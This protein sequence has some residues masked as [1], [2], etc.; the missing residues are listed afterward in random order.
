MQRGQTAAALRGGLAAND[1]GA[2]AEGQRPVPSGGAVGDRGLRAAALERRGGVELDV[3]IAAATS[4]RGLRDETQA[5]RYKGIS[6]LYQ[7]VVCIHQHQSDGVFSTIITN[8]AFDLV[9]RYLL[10]QS[11]QWHTIHSK[12]FSLYESMEAGRQEDEDG[13]ETIVYLLDYLFS[14]LPGLR[15]VLTGNSVEECTL[16]YFCTMLSDRLRAEPYLLNSYLRL[17]ASIESTS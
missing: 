7:D 8:V 5:F 10:V 11:S 16:P 17:R 15:I 1:A 3:S 6:T 13:L 4:R 9:S 12:Q 2:A 14:H